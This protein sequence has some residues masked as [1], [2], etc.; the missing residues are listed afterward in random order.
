MKF[1]ANKIRGRWRI[2]HAEK[3]RLFEKFLPPFAE[4]TNRQCAQYL[5]RFLNEHTTNAQAIEIKVDDPKDPWAKKQ[6]LKLELL[7][8]DE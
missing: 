5:E 8:V 6:A 1:V 2:Y 7:I 4:P 3:K